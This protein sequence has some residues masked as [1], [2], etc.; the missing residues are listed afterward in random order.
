M[1]SL[2]RFEWPLSRTM[3]FYTQG[4]CL[5]FFL[6]LS[7]I[8]GWEKNNVEVGLVKNGR[9]SCIDKLVLQVC[10]YANYV[11]K[12]LSSI[13]WSPR[14]SGGRLRRPSITPDLLVAPPSNDFYWAEVSRQN[15][16]GKRRESF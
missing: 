8:Y 12:A 16:G 10:R 2:G 13:I 5:N 15:F 1:L 9:F 11:R 6:C 14:R 7:I 3:W 4:P